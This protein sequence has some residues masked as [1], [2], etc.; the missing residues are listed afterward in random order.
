MSIANPEG[1]SKL[2]AL[3]TAERSSDTISYGIAETILGRVLVARSARGVCAILIGENQEELR[4]DLAR[5]FP[6]A[7]IRE[8]PGA[9]QEEL[10][11]VALFVDGDE[12]SVDLPLDLHGTEFQRKVWES[13]M[14]I[15]AGTTMTYSEL[16]Q[17]IGKPRAVRAVAGACAANPVAL[18]IPCHRVV[19]SNGEL[20][21]YAWGVER[22][23]ALLEREA[24]A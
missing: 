12:G 13:L 6:R 1:A 24:Q 21:G 20:A 2:D 15:P 19:R 4:A 18:A 22:K 16:A 3:V 23:R 7:A 9:V 17:Q 11:N 8:D 10:R 14:A 5:R